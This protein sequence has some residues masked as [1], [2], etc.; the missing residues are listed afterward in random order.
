VLYVV[1]G[2]EPHNSLFDWGEKWVGTSLESIYRRVPTSTAPNRNPT[3]FFHHPEVLACNEEVVFVAGWHQPLTKLR[4]PD[5][6]VEYADTDHSQSI[7]GLT[8]HGDEL[9]C[10]R[11]YEND[12]EV[13]NVHTMEVT[14]RVGHSDG[15][16]VAHNVD[17]RRPKSLRHPSALMVV[18]DELYVCDEYNHRVQVFDAA[19]GTYVRTLG[20]KGPDYMELLRKGF[21]ADHTMTKLPAKAGR[22]DQSPKAICVSPNGSIVVTEGKGWKDK[23]GSVH[24]FTPQGAPLQLFEAPSNCDI[25]N[26]ICASIA[27][28][29]AFIGGG[30]SVHALEFV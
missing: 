15:T 23:N 17:E 18:H 24:V 3:L 20:Y 4:L 1:G 7:I 25:D 16:D 28:N 21:F 12:V 19:S 13:R 10:S 29:R 30:S 2:P 14:R 22:F 27:V 5:F 6:E 9:F 8:I 26:G 11:V